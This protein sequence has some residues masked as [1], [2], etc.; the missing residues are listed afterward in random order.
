MVLKNVIEVSFLG[1]YGTTMFFFLSL[2]V[3]VSVSNM[4]S[5]CYF[6]A[7]II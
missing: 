3:S 2:E 6:S 4:T 7:T 5:K 1:G